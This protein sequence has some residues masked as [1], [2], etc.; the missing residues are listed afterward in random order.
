MKI[1][2]V[3]YDSFCVR[4]QC[5]KIVTKDCKIMI[6]P[7][8]ALGP[9]RYGLPPTEL[10]RETLENAKK[11]ILEKSRDC[12]IIIITHYHYDHIPRPEEDEIIQEIFKNKKVYSK[13]IH[14]FINY[15]QRDRG[16]EFENSVKKIT[17]KYYYGDDKE[18]EIGNTTISLSH[19]VF[20]GEVKTKL[21]YVLMVSVKRGKES[22][23]YGSDAEGPL[24]PNGVNFII[25]HNPSTTILDG[26]ITYMLHYRL[27]E[28]NLN[29]S[30]ENMKKIIDNIR[31]EKIV[32]DHH[33]VRDLN[34]KERIK[35]LTK[36]ARENDKKIIT[37]GDYIGEENKLLE[38]KREELTDETS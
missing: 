35:P 21:G 32:Y 3:C 33:L 10:E 36:Y 6:D 19:P 20:H 34:Y 25:E 15:S 22:F 28:K 14:K 27:S 4:S 9:R 18:F 29:K 38:A 2:P 16:R 30:I 23:V 17:D 26:P 7:G 37:A 1:I 13:N 5:T 24:D 31:A 11:K 8:A 12:D